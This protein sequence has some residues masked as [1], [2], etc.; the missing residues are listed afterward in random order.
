MQQLDGRE[1]SE[2]SSYLT[3]YQYGSKFLKR[4][5]VSRHSELEPS[6]VSYVSKKTMQA[7]TSTFSSSL[8]A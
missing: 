5:P 8:S 4:T 7:V 3:S 6:I 2:G 1:V